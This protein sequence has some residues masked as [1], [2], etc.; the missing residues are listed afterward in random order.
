MNE[1]IGRLEKIGWGHEV[2]SGTPVAATRWIPKMDGSFSPNVEKADDTSAYGTIEQLRSKV[3]V[4]Q[5]TDVEVKGVVRDIY[6]GDL[7][8]MALGSE[9]PTL[10]AAVSSNTS[11]LVGEN[12]TQAGSGAVGVVQRKE[13]TTLL[14]ISVTSGVFTSGSGVITGGTSAATG[15]PTFETTLRY[16]FFKRL[17][18][19]N[20]PAYTIYGVDDTGTYRSGYCMLDSLELELNVN[21]YLMFN[22]KWLGKLE[23]TTTATPA[24]S[25]TENHFLGKHA[26]FYIATNLAG[27]A[28]ASPT[29]IQSLKLTIEKN[30]EAYQAWGSLD[31]ASIHNKQFRVTGEI[32]ALFN[33]TTLKDF[34]LTSAEKALRI[35]LVNTD[36]T[37]GGSANPE[38]VIDL[39]KVAFDDWSKKA[40]NDDL[41]MQTLGFEM[42]YSVAD[43][44][45]IVAYLLN[46]QTTAY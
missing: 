10:K 40:G 7:L 11:F 30:L 9:I 25:T 29:P 23:S 12:V 45:G 39:A 38:L 46:S 5:M 27:L 1:H 41:V 17:N 4:K 2:T 6:G 21:G 32:T 37:I 18:N 3:T 43:A 24:F 13:G 35:K 44:E 33:A 8:L 36:V 20:H 42:E 28:A 14:Y 16:H 22:A 34:V 15:T 19:N 26:N 31:V